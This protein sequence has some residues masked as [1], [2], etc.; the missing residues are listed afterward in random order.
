MLNNA[1]VSVKGTSW[2]G[3]DNWRKL[4]DVNLFGWVSLPRRRRRRS[5]LTQSDSQRY[6][7]AAHVRART[8]G[9]LLLHFGSTAHLEIVSLFSIAFWQSML[10]QENQ[11]VVINTGSKQGITNPPYAHQ[12]I[13][14]L[15][16]S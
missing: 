10:H 15:R 7:R 12:Q 13:A 14:S 16:E 4:M 11:S 8:L 1:A 2:E 6:Q 5:S 9:S 3:L